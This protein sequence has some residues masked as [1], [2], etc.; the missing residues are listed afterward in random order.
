MIERLSEK[1]TSENIKI[2]KPYLEIMIEQ[3]LI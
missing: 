1:M 3:R 2:W